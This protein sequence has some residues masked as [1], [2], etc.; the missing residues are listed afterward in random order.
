MSHSELSLKASDGVNLFAEQ[1]LPQGE[2]RAS[3]NLI[4]GLGEHSGRYAHVARALNAA[5][6]AVTAIDLRGHGKSPGTRGHIPS[7]DTA[8]GDIN[9]LIAL[10]TAQFPGI[11]QFLYGHSLGGALVLY[12]SL[13]H[14]PKVRGTIATSPGLDPGAVPPAK[15]LMAKVLSQL[16]PSFTMKNGLDVNNLSH[17]FAV[18]KNYQADPLVHPMIS[19]RLGYELINNGKKISEFKGE[20]PVPLLLLQGAKDHLVNAATNARFANQ[21]K[22]QCTF[23]MFEEGYH[24][25][26]NEPWKEEVFKVIIDWVDSHIN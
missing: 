16:A 12:T 22:A 24:E 17:D 8:S 14:A 2:V 15:L 23:K 5:G 25:L 21:L 13:F 11:P 6:F 18:I 10:T 4:H 1:W 19:T 9:Q 7:Y 26:H 3:I 20:F